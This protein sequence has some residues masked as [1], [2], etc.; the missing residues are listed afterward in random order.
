MITDERKLPRQ[1]SNLDKENQNLLGSQPNPL[2][3]TTSGNLP[4]RPDRART[5]P[6][7]ADPDL[8][9]LLAAWPKLAPAI[10]KAILALVDAGQ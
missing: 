5:K 4:K 7:A 3:H 9:R 10:R 2:P 1:D 8:D 6:P